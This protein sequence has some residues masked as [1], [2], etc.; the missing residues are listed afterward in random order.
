MCL[1]RCLHDCVTDFCY[2]E[3]FSILANINYLTSS[4][5]VLT[6]IIYS[7]DMYNLE[8][9]KLNLKPFMATAF[10]VLCMTLVDRLM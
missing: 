3:I 5:L 4:F 8:K 7:Y 1:I 10:Y 2:S 6:N 9:D